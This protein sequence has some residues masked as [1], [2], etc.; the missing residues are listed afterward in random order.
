MPRYVVQQH[1]RS[2]D[3]WHFDLMFEAGQAL[4]TFSSHAPPDACAQ[5]PCLVRHLGDHRLAYL[6]YEGEISGGSP[7]PTKSASAL[8]AK[9]PTEPSNSSATPPAAPIIGG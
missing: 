5:L 4:V 9:R 8:P 7:R 3:D 2:E 6:E 1:F